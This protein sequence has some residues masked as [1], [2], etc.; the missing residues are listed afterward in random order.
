MIRGKKKGFTVILNSVLKDPRLGLKTIGLFAIMQSFP[1]DWEYSVKGLAARAG[2]GRDTIRNCLKELEE[3]GYLSREQ[4]H[5]ENGKF[6]G[7]VYTL[8]EESQQEEVPSEAPK[9]HDAQPLTEKPTSAQPTSANLPQVNKQL[10]KK[11][12]KKNPLTPKGGGGADDDKIPRPKHDPEAFDIFWAAYPRKDD[13]AASVKA[14]NRLKP[15]R[16]VC[17]IMY[18]ALKQHKRSRQWTK[19]SGQ[20]IPTFATWL[21][22]QKWR[23]QGVDLAMFPREDAGGWTIDPELY[24]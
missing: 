19:D 20:Y 2:V 21:K 16:G 15:S 18:D 13:L 4:Q 23:N 24:T 14:W 22:G 6:G 3:A 10:S 9:P 1:D 5:Q 7:C 8:Q 11:T 12:K 17:R